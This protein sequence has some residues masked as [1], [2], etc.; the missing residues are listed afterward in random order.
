MAEAFACT[1]E[2]KG[3]MHL[4]VFTIH[5]TSVFYP[6]TDYNVISPRQFYC[7]ITSQINT[8]NTTREYQ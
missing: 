7:P 3:Y 6:T 2:H 4:L 1:V 8:Q 5:Y